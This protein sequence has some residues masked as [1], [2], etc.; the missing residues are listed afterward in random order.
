MWKYYWPLIFPFAGFMIG[1]K[2]DHMESERF[3]MFRDK[4][5]L[6]GR[7]LKPGEPPSWGY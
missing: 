7:E 2:L 3:S 4:S 1:H 5:A 6:Y